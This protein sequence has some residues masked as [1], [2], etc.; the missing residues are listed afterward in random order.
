MRGSRAA[1]PKGTK[2]Y[3]TQGDFRSSFCPEFMAERPDLRRERADF[4]PERVDFS[5][6]RAEF[7]FK[8]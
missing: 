4:S 6:E 7:K 3:R 8:A 5:P 2:S 1:A